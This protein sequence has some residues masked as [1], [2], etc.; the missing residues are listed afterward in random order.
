MTDVSTPA[1]THIPGQGL[2]WVRTLLIDQNSRCCHSVYCSQP[3]MKLCRCAQPTTH[4]RWKVNPI[5]VLSSSL[6]QP[7]VSLQYMSSTFRSVCLLS[8]T[9]THTNTNTQMEMLLGQPPPVA[10]T[11]YISSVTP[12]LKPPEEQQ[13]QQDGKKW[14]YERGW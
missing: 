2:Q 12:H 4:M 1:H 13:E 14:R 3:I 7:L 8:D 9:H 11:Q 10:V 6:L 5:S